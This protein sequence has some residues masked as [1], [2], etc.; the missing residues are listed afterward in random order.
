MV[1]MLLMILI[2]MLILMVLMVVMLMV[3]IF[4]QVLMAAR[5]LTVS[6]DWSQAT[7][8]PRPP[9]NQLPVECSL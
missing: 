6:T 8:H 7:L 2:L 5:R 9:V 1:L 4:C 3:L